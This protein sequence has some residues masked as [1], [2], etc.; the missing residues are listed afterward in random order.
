MKPVL[1]QRCHFPGIRYPIKSVIVA[2]MDGRFVTEHLCRS[3]AKKARENF[4]RSEIAAQVAQE[5]IELD[6]RLSSFQESKAKLSKGSRK[7]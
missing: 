6:A 2:Y 1:C 5:R 4:S 7:C 3:C